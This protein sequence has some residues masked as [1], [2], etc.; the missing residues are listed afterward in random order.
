MKGP[1]LA[2]ALSFMALGVCLVVLLIS[3]GR[4]RA[5]SLVEVAGPEDVNIHLRASSN[6]IA[7]MCGGKEVADVCLLSAETCVAVRKAANHTLLCRLAPALPWSL[8]CT[9]SHPRRLRDF[10]FGA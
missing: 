1:Q 2:G 9:V 7:W 5:V 4:M 3:F 8:F 10:C 6:S